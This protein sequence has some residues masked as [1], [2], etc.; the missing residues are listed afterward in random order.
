MV[1]HDLAVVDYMCDRFAVMQAGDIVEILGRD[2]LEGNKA[3][4]LYARQLIDA[5]LEYDS[6]I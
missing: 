3:T 6:A 4:H 5:S 2:A 1:S